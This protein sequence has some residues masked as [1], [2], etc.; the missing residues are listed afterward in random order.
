MK[1]SL[2]ILM[3]RTRLLFISGKSQLEH[4]PRYLP[5]NKNIVGKYDSDQKFVVE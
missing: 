2:Y 5:L 3:T 1:R 4:L